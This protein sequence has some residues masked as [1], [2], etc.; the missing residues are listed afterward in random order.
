MALTVGKLR[1]ILKSRDIPDDLPIAFVHFAG[2]REV[3]TTAE[4]TAIIDRDSKSNA[5]LTGR[6]RETRPEFHTGS[7][8]RVFAIYD[9]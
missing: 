6:I 5:P 2:T 8:E 1:E 7:A 4:G 3:S 9:E